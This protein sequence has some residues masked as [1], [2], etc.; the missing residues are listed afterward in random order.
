MISSRDQYLV[1]CRKDISKYDSETFERTLI[2]AGKSVDLPQYPE[3]KGIVRAKTYVSGFY[4]KEIGNDECEVHFIAETDF[5]LSMM[6]M[7]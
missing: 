1:F 6:I 5:K 2:L 4:V 7:K 3:I